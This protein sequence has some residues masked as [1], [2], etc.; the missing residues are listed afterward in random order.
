MMTS[1][2]LLAACLAFGQVDGAAAD[3]L[4]SQVGGLV[5]RLDS[6]KL[7]TRNAAEQQLVELGP[8]VLDWLDE[9]EK[10]G[11]AEVKQR[12][13][14]VRSRLEQQLAEKA[15]QASLITLRGKM[16]L[17]AALENIQ[18]QT[19]NRVVDYRPRFN[20]QPVDPEIHADFQRVPFWK[21]LDDILDQSGLT[22]Y[23]YSGQ[24]RTLAI[25]ARDEGALPR[26]GRGSYSG[27][28]RIQAAQ[29]EAVRDLRN[30]AN[31]S[32]RLTLEIL[33]EPRVIPIMIRQPLS[34]VQ[35]DAD[36]G[37][38]LTLASRTGRLD[39]NV[40]STVSGVEL[41][42][43]LGLPG[44]N[45]RKIASLKGK[46]T[47]LVPGRVATYEFDN[48]SSAKNVMQKKAGVTVILQEVRKNADIYEFQVRIRFDDA[49]DSLQSHLDW[50]SNNEVYL[51]GPDG[52]QVTDL[53]F[54]RFADNMKDEVGYRYLCP[55]DG[56]LADYKF[57]YKSPGAILVLPVEYEL[58][59]IELP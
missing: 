2:L 33:W 55:L 17:S 10:R 56:D 28:F 57:V 14:R 30:P 8:G 20:Q 59:D 25:V 24:P 37:L 43:P 47:A 23:N 35:V 38:T 49:A 1:S 29:I 9:F 53:N 32:L 34:E 21:A 48:L 15:G 13:V 50:V 58:T 31:H 19:G 7:A 52:R 40:Q 51:V 5:R 41:I 18:Q 26:V 27:L 6:D 54:E 11:S 16:K 45:V 36:E 39:A 42:M 3:E 22:V 46:F 4:R 44:R 12:L